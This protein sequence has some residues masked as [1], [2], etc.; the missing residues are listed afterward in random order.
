MRTNL[1]NS[2]EQFYNKRNE[3]KLDFDFMD[4][5][6]SQLLDQKQVKTVFKQSVD[7]NES[8]QEEY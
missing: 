4:R 8:S 2:R 5:K 1:D 7:L 6:E 3:N